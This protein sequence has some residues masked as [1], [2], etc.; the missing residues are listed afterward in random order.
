MAK[1]EWKLFSKATGK[2]LSCGM[3]VTYLG[4][5]AYISGIDPR[6]TWVWVLRENDESPKA[7][8]ARD[9]NAHFKLLPQISD[10]R[11]IAI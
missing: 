3:N 7:C 9:I 1:N 10:N 8:F 6:G 5:D 4:R 2:E 11:K